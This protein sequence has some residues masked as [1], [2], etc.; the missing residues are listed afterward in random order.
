MLQLNQIFKSNERLMRLLWHDCDLAYWIDVQDPK[1]WPTQVLVS[2]IE[3][4]LINSSLELAEDP[5][6]E[7][8]SRLYDETTINWQKS[9]RAWKII[10]PHIDNPELFHRNERGKIV[11]QLCNE[12][13]VTHQSVNRYLRRYWQ[14]GMCMQALLPDYINSG[15]AGKRRDTT[16]SK[17][18]RKRTITNGVGTNVSSDMERIFRL[19]VENRLLKEKSPSVRDAYSS[20]LNLIKAS[21][22]LTNDELPT[23]T[24]FRYFIK[25][26]YP[27]TKLIEAQSSDIQFEKDIAPK[28][29]TSTSETLGPG[30]RYQ[31]DATIADIYLLSEYDRSKVVGRPVIYFVADVYS[32]MIVG[33]YV[34]FEGP[35]WISAMMALSNAFCCKVE[36]CRN[37]GIEIN[38]DD[39]PVAGLPDKI[40]ADQGEFKGTLVEPF[41]C[42]HGSGIENAKARR[43]DAKGIVEREFRTVQSDFKPY[44]EG[45]VEPVISKKRGGK[46]YRLDATLT[47]PEFTQKI[48]NIV[49]YHNNEHKMD[50]YDRSEGLPTDVPSIALNLWN[51]GISNLTGRLR[52]APEELVKINLLPHRKATVSEWGICIFGAYYTCSEVIQRGWLHRIKNHRPDS[53][54]VAYDPR[55]TN[56]IYIRPDNNLE[57]FWVCELTDRSRRFRDMTFWDLWRIRREENKTNSNQDISSALAKGKL[58]EKLESIEKSAIEQKPDLSHLSKASQVANIKQNKQAEKA[59]ERRKSALKPVKT[60]QTQNTEVIPI[61]S[62]EEEDYSYP[63][64][65][66]ILFEDDDHE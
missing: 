56:H 32:R 6:R 51:W 4:M 48:I 8:R 59:Q 37:F 60:N 28:L 49:L 31:I 14:R 57:H 19:S 36:Y 16:K 55:N 15:G 63:D 44:T 38:K 21:T 17:L 35:S 41:I 10:E 34:G 54:H 24:Q 5:F 9:Q 52:T 62:Q 27:K 29:S 2:K 47:L 61:S 46:D 64:M 50:K 45:I 1:A 7:I 12:H 40:L 22:Q 39:W 65:T 20:A 3:L 33:M 25:R 18:G 66:D 58:I 42:A 11:K 23:I 43:G 13:K 26:E 53:V 30:Y